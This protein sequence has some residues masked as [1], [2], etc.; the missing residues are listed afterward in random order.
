MLKS[1]G[2]PKGCEPREGDSVTNKYGKIGDKAPAAFK[3]E[4]H[5]L[6]RCFEAALS[7]SADAASIGSLW[8]RRR[9]KRMNDDGGRKRVKANLPGSLW[10]KPREC[11]PVPK[12][13]CTN[14]GRSRARA[15]Q[16]AR[17][18]CA[19]PAPAPSQVLCTI[20]TLQSSGLQPAPA[21]AVA[22]PVW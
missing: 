12:R 11:V 2:K 7:A 15:A 16:V 3:V 9:D 14:D 1:V 4:T 17:Y 21:H 8:E 20:S 6:S 10:P 13:S 19:H 5:G 18:S 22:A